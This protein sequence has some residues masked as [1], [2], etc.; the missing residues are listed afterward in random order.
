M[1]MLGRMR[2]ESELSTARAAGP[3]GRRSRALSMEDE[4]T[5]KA[6]PTALETSSPLQ[7]TTAERSTSLTNDP[8]PS[9]TPKKT[10]ATSTATEAIGSSDTK[11][12]PSTSPPRTSRT[13]PPT[14]EESTNTPSSSLPASIPTTP[15]SSS[16]QSWPSSTGTERSTSITDGPPASQTSIH[17]GPEHHEPLSNG[18]TAGIVLS[19]VAVLLGALV[20]LRY[21]YKKRGICGRGG[22]FSPIGGPYYSGPNVGSLDSSV[23]TGN[24][25]N[26]REHPGARAHATPTWPA[27]HPSTGLRSVEMQTFTRLPHQP[28]MYDVGQPSAGQEH[29]G[30]PTLPQ[31]QIDLASPRYHAAVLP[32]DDGFQA[33]GYRAW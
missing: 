3:T 11:T 27:T 31:I 7:N 5:P 12:L 17:G 20:L 21:I 22:S 15:A 16:Q 9:S 10:P 18:A 29:S 28:K 2:L 14:A 13:Q 6:R 30:V 26:W 24:P 4:R 1:S 32:W 33:D 8:I 19:V 23:Q 25:D